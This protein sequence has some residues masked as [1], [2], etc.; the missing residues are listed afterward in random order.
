MRH[1]TPHARQF[2]R[3]AGVATLAALLAASTTANARPGTWTE[4]GS[5]H[6]R[7]VLPAAGAIGGRIYVAGGASGGGEGAERVEVFDP[8]TGVW[9]EKGPFLPINQGFA[10]GVVGGRFYVI[11]GAQ[12]AVTRQYN[13]V[14]DGWALNQD[15]PNPLYLAASAVASGKVYAF[16]IAAPNWTTVARVFDPATDSW[17]RVADAPVSVRDA[18]AASVGGKV[19]LIG[20]SSGPTVA[21]VQEYDPSADSWEVREDMPTPR[22]DLSCVEVGGLIYAIG[23]I[24]AGNA[25]LSTVEVYDPRADR[26]TRAA[27]MPVGRYWFAAAALGASIY[28]IGGNSS[29]APGAAGYLDRVDVYDTGATDLAVDNHE[30][31]ATTWGAMKTGR[32]RRRD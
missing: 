30:K 12:S 19:Y 4:T 22:T 10:Y 24:G 1:E 31:L 17:T 18:C 29:R 11:G 27:D 26:W 20:G 6:T 25:V 13:P 21:A 28:A 8:R 23:G 3:L 14:T 9:T 32:E 7:R 5:L 2:T 16:R 15:A